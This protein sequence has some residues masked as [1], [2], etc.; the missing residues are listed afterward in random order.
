[1]TGAREF[2]RRNQEGNPM[3]ISR[4][5]GAARLLVLFVLVTATSIADET[6]EKGRAVLAAHKDAVITVRTVLSLSFGNTPE[7]R[8]NE[9]NGTVIDPEGLTVLSLTSVDP[10]SL[11]SKM[12]A[13]KR[14]VVS[15]VS[16]MKMILADGSEIE[17][18][19]VLR[20]VDLD[21]AF[22][23][24]IAKPAE[25]MPHVNLTA[26]GKP[27]VLDEL[28]I[29][30]QL[31]QVARRA[32]SVLV[33]RVETIIDK[34][35]TFY[36]LGEH[37]ARAVVCSPA[38]TLDGAFVGIG[39]FRSISSDA[40]GGMGDNVLVVVISAN[41]IREAALQVPPWP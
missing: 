36:V 20:D 7:E 23:R 17:A 12:G 21:L 30:A 33:E 37:R 32:H 13:G 16:G 19:V 26:T 39:V 6:A 8:T 1:M 10:S 18:E 41:D 5:F 3:I 2:A 38:F 4:L 27:D 24:P 35:R 25:P 15:K 14:E 9:A 40:A 31:G 29:L 11:M 28:V 34:P 22:V